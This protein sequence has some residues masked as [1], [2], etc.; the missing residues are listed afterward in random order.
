MVEMMDEFGC[1]TLIEYPVIMDNS[2]SDLTVNV[3]SI[4]PVDCTDLGRA[5]IE[6]DN[7][8]TSS[9]PLNLKLYSEGS[10]AL[11]STLS[12]SQSSIDLP[13]GTYDYMEIESLSGCVR[14][15][16]GFTISGS[17]G[18]Q[19]NNNIEADPITVCAG[20]VVT[21]QAL[22]DQ[23]SYNWSNGS[24]LELVNIIPQTDAQFWVDMEDQ[25]GCIT[26]MNFDVL[27][28]HQ[29]DIYKDPIEVGCA[30]ARISLIGDFGYESYT[31]NN[32][33]TDRALIV[34]PTQ[35]TE[36]WV[37]V[38]DQSGC[39]KRIHYPVIIAAPIEADYI[40]TNANT[41]GQGI[42]Q[43]IFSSN[44]NNIFPVS[45]Y[46]TSNGQETLIGEMY[47]EN[48]SFPLAGGLYSDLNLITSEGC[49]YSLGN[50]EI[51]TEVIC[52]NEIVDNP[53]STVCNG[54]L[55]TLE[56]EPG[57]ISY[58]WSNGSTVQ[59]ISVQVQGPTVFSVEM[60][61]SNGCVKTLNFPVDIG[62]S[63]IISNEDVTACI[64]KEVIL[65]AV[66][67]YNEYFWSTG[68]TTQTITVSPT[69]A[70]QYTVELIDGSICNKTQV[71]NIVPTQIINA[72]FSVTNAEVGIDGSVSITILNAS[73]ISF[74]ISVKVNH[75]G[76]T[77]LLGEMMN[78]QATFSVSPGL[79]SELRVTSADLCATNLGEFQI[80]EPSSE[81]LQEITLPTQTICEGEVILL[82][83]PTGYVDFEWNSGGNGAAINVS[84][85]QST[86]YWVKATDPQTGQRWQI[87]HPIIV[88]QNVNGIY[89]AIDESNNASGRIEITLLNPP[90]A[91]AYP[92]AVLATSNGQQSLIGNMNY[93]ATSINLPVG[94][95]TDLKLITQHDCEFILGDFIINPDPNSGEQTFPPIQ[96]CLA[97]MLTIDAPSG[98]QTYQW[99][100]GS[101]SEDLSI[102]V[103]GG[104]TYSVTM[105]DANG[106]TQINHYPVE[107]SLFGVD[108]NQQNDTNWRVEMIYILY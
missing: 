52:N 58:L 4:P 67:G 34:G 62:Q 75:S 47:S 94:S 5:V 11:V 60:T 93:T 8:N 38:I 19:V 35:D 102:L 83:A 41:N 45:I 57:Y 43:I 64:N 33:H 56:A 78:D 16:A 54:N 100:N 81:E 13:V 9:L 15:Y 25:N 63:Q 104:D 74:P 97:Q 103:F 17:S 49:Q 20:N 88:N 31:W 107:V 23:V 98:Y 72:E 101:S 70:A 92:I 105:T 89:T 6:L 96:G 108:F 59:N 69:A 84:P 50:F 73:S 36:Y 3:I 71:F 28:S 1:T 12:Q 79:Y 68:A 46:A 2:L 18:S 40:V 7:V 14:E 44:R 51:T 87:F 29:S 77:L 10:L 76:Q 42:L 80:Q 22:T 61:D 26:R 48:R 95:Y 91:T 32:G 39:S 65:S 86:T 85:S 106:G 90:D 24:T 21:L 66:S 55:L 53:L 37:D 99:S 27:V 30:N 82:N